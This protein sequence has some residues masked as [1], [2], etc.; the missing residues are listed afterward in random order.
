[1]NHVSFDPKKMNSR[2]DSQ[3]HEGAEVMK[4]VCVCVCI[5]MCV[6]CVCVWC[7]CM[8]ADMC[9]GLALHCKSKSSDDIINTVSEPDGRSSCFGLCFH[10]KG[11][12]SLH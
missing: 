9:F 6:V 4:C 1:M 12:Q 7:M 2:R 3:F 11:N 10:S 5:C 8:C